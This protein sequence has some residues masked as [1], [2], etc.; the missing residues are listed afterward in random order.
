MAGQDFTVSI[1]GT[2]TGFDVAPVNNLSNSLKT[3]PPAA[4]Q[5]ATAG[6]SLSSSMT[7]VGTTTRATGSQFQ[8]TGSLAN[9][10]GSNINTARGSAQQLVGTNSALGSSFGSVTQGGLSA[11]NTLLPLQ[12]NL[13]KTT[14]QSKAT[15][16]SSISLGEKIA[17]MGGFITTTVGHIF[18]LIEGFTGL[19]A[20]QVAADRAQ[21]RVNTSELAAEK[22]QDA[23]NKVVAKFGPES[24]QAQEALVN[25]Q[26]KQEANRIAEERAEVTS[27]KLQEAYVSFGL[28]IINTV[29]EMATMGSTISILVGKLGLKTAATVVDTDANIANGASGDVAA[30]GFAAEAL[31]AEGAAVATGEAETAAAGLNIEL[32]AIAAPLIAAAALFVLIE[33]N[34]FGMGDAF[35]SIT[36]QIGQFVD[37]IVNGAALI[38]NGFIRAL[39]GVIQF[40]GNAANAFI[41]VENAINTFLDQVA[42]GFI[43]LGQDIQNA[44]SRIPNFFIDNLINPIIG[45]WNTFT[46]ALVT[47]WQKTTNA[48]VDFFKPAAQAIIDVIKRIVDAGAQIPGALGD[49]FRNA[50][51]GI[52][53][54]AE[55]LKKVGTQASQTGQE[56]KTGLDPIPKVADLATTSF[57]HLTTSGLYPTNKAFI[58][59]S[60][61]IKILDGAIIQN[62]GNIKTGAAAFLDYWSKGENLAAGLKGALGPALQQTAKFIQDGTQSLLG[63]FGP[64]A[65]A[66][67]ETDKFGGAIGKAQKPVKDFAT[68]LAEATDKV[69]AEAAGVQQA[70]AAHQFAAKAIAETSK[71][72]QDAASKQQELTTKLTDGTAVQNRYNTAIIEGTNKYL[73]LIVKTQDA[74]T[75]QQQYNDLL[76]RSGAGMAALAL[77]LDDTAKNMELVAKAALGDKDA[78]AELQGEVTKLYDNFNKLGDQVSSKLVD[79]LDKGKKAW[80]KSIKEL[81]DETGVSFKALGEDIALKVDAGLQKAQ[82]T[83][84]TDLGVMAVLIRQHAPNIGEATNEMIDQLAE[85][86]KGAQPEVIAAWNKVFDDMR[87]IAAEPIPTAASLGQLQKD[88]SALHLP[89]GQ[90]EAIMSQLRGTIGGVGG[91]AAGAT[92]GITQYSNGLAAAADLNAGFSRGVS[93]AIGQLNI[94][95]QAGATTFINFIPALA[96]VAAAMNTAFVRGVGDAIGQLNLLQTAAGTVFLTIVSGLE[97]VVNGFNIAF[98]EA[99][100]SAGLALNSLTVNIN[101][102]VATWIKDIASATTA[103][104]NDFNA[105]TKSAG[106]VMNG[107]STN[108]NG[109]AQ[110]WIKAFNAAATALTNGFNTGTKNAGVAMNSLASN[111]NTNSSNMVSSIN[112]VVSAMNNIGS[113]ASSARSQVQSLINSINSIPSSKTV[114]INIV[115]HRTVVT[116]TVPAPASASLAASIGTT[117]SATLAGETK[118]TVLAPGIQSAAAG[119]SRRITLEIKEPTV[120]KIDSRELIKLIN[121]KLLELD[122]G[123]LI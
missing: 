88:I 108:I 89:A 93:D 76:Q 79:S 26:N 33:T 107:L 4:Q 10:F 95:Q 81:S 3:I 98:N 34:T 119:T 57:E 60:G 104:V 72:L 16:E 54:A 21:Q 5:A 61:V 70:V 42:T 55:S 58:D 49:P 110:N 113:A 74:V 116:R 65:K 122:I 38:Y 18:G 11:N 101:G 120:I 28:E 67:E 103:L 36:P 41:G 84:D 32:L 22:A 45:A 56:A 50:K 83:L 31:G 94:L 39:E 48:I 86:I 24:K 53:A 99:T 105:A 118:T 43:N 102:N 15:E 112:R 52:D 90:A 111:V 87:K 2:V 29:G 64:A 96:A 46:Q 59:T 1:V 8:A 63:W 71:A 68:S 27:K 13:Q 80:N 109:N 6:Q 100:K 30:A 117:T 44:I 115:E 37:I 85:N 7:Q 97:Q 40:T 114:T 62:A 14:T 66:T 17:L 19:E 23:Y 9:A 91:A 106:T 92:G 78:F 47:A 35:R 73:D 51:T 82:K 69:N 121:K 75:T 20:A 12:Q 77:G 25:M 123:A